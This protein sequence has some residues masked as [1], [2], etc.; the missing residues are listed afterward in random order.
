MI[1]FGLLIEIYAFPADNKL[2]SRSGGIGER[3]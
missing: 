2:G 1:G 3:S